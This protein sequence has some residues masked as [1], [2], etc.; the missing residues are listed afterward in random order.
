MA[1]RRNLFAW[2]NLLFSRLISTTECTLGNAVVDI[3][4]LHHSLHQALAEASPLSHVPMVFRD[5]FP[6][7]FS[8][9]G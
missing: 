4:M 2:F 6:G 1:C 5:V 7:K 9:Q 3:W 8:T